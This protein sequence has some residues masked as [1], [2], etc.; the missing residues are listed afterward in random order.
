VPHAE[1]LVD[2]SKLHAGFRSDPLA[3]V[4]DPQVAQVV[5]DEPAG[6]VIARR[7][8]SGDR[9][10]QAMIESAAVPAQAKRSQIV[11]PPEQPA[12]FFAVSRDPVGQV[13]A[14]GKADQFCAVALPQILDDLQIRVVKVVP[15][16]HARHDH[17]GVEVRASGRR[18]YKRI[19]E[20]L[21]R[22]DARAQKA[23]VGPGQAGIWL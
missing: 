11:S 6:A 16:V 12:R 22:P 7:E 3:V 21:R 14:V 4:G 18:R 10:G 9:A 5:F 8:L 23:D 13:I 15:H 20:L 1:A 2:G 19:P 17:D